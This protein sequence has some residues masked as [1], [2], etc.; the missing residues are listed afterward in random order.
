MDCV[1]FKKSGKLFK[2][3]LVIVDVSLV[4][5]GFYLTFL[6]LSSMNLDSNSID[7]FVKMIPY[8]SIIVLIFFYIY[9]VFNLFR[10]SLAER[11]YSI[12]LSLIMIDIAAVIINFLIMD[13]RYS[14]SIFILAYFI[15]IILLVVWKMTVRTVTKKL[16]TA[17]RM[18]IIG[19]KENTKS[20]SKKILS[21]KKK[22]MTQIKYICNTVDKSTY[23]LINEIDE[24]F[25]CLGLDSDQKADIIYYCIGAGKV[26]YIIPDLFEIALLKS[27]MEQFDDIPVFKIDNIHLSLEQQIVKRVMDIF[28][29]CIGIVIFSPI[30][31]IVSVIIKLYDGGPVLFNQERVTIG[32]SIFKLYKFRT[33]IVD[34]E[35][36]TGPILAME[37]DPRITPIGKIL[38]VTRIDEFP[39]LFNVIK[40]E[41]SIVGPRPERTFFIDQFIKEIPEFQYR[42]AVKAGITGLAQV[43]SKYTTSPENKLRYDLLYIKNYSIFLDIKIMFQ[44]IKVMVMMESSTGQ[45]EAKVVEETFK[46]LQYKVFEE[47]GTSKLDI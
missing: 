34:A 12:V 7:R 22:Y 5:S 37:K 20:I 4:V 13:C 1:Y 45:K 26:V 28:V 6:L 16:Y 27:Q 11:I 24:V 9:H 46:E 32:G 17:K 40:G 31:L 3:I 39:Q 41:M 30:F 10:V 38:R 36:F 15:Q 43:L 47:V 35:K 25:I 21:D 33:M 2:C 8:L 19:S 44:T 14:L 18:L 29:S 42:V 23:K